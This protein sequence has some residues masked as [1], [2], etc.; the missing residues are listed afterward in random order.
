MGSATLA[1]L[2]SYLLPDA[3]RTWIRLLAVFSLLAVALGGLLV[4]HDEDARP[5]PRRN[6]LV[7]IFGGMILLM[8]IFAWSDAAQ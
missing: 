1:I 2:V 3:P 6:R 4:I 8:G 5:G 7:M